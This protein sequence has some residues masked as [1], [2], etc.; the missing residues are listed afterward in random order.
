[1]MTK[2][3]EKAQ[4][5]VKQIVGQMIGD[6][7]LVVEGKEQQQKAEHEGTAGNSD[8]GV[9]KERKDE[10]PKHEQA[11]GVRKTSGKKT[12]SKKASSDKPASR[13]QAR[14]PAVRKGPI[15]D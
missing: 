3:Q 15:L 4:A 10:P 14:D 6:E 9:A 12:S 5:Q 1:M 11:Q 8:Q 7:K 2:L 13:K